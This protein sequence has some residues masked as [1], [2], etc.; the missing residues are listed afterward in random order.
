MS[1]PP[2]ISA[3]YTNSA[4]INSFNDGVVD[5]TTEQDGQGLK[6]IN[7]TTSGYL[8]ISSAGAIVSP[9]GVATY[10]I[11]FKDLSAITTNTTPQELVVV[12]TIAVQDATT[13]PP[14]NI[15]IQAGV[16]G[17]GTNFGIEYSSSTD[18]DF[19]IFCDENN[20][21]GVLYKQQGFGATTTQTKIKQG[22]ITITDTA[23]A[24]V[25]TT[26]TPQNITITNSGLSNTP[27][28]TL[29]SGTGNAII[30]EEMYNQR[31]AQTGE[32]NRMGFYAKNSAGTK[33][34][35]ARFHTNAPTITAGGENGRIDLAV[36]RSGAIT[37][38][39]SL[40]GSANQVNCLRTLDMN[41]NQINNIF[42][43]N[44]TFFSTLAPQKVSYLTANDSTPTSNDPNMRQLYI[45]TGVPPSLQSVGTAPLGS[46]SPISASATYNGNTYVGTTDGQIYYT[47]DP[48]GSWFNLGVLL[49]GQINCFKEFNGDLYF[50]GAFTSDFNTSTTYNNIGR[51]TNTPA[52]V[53]ITWSNIGQTGLNNQ[54]L[55]F[56]T[57]NNYLY[58]GGAFTQDG[59]NI[60]TYNFLAIVDTTNN[61]YNTNNTSTDGFNNYVRTITNDTGS[62]RFIIGGDFSTFTTGGSSFTQNYYTHIDFDS[63]TSYNVFGFFTLNPSL[64]SSVNVSVKDTNTN[65]IIL[66]GSFTSTGYTDYMFEMLWNGS[67]Y[68][69]Q[70]F[71]YTSPSTSPSFLTR[72]L[73]TSYIYWGQSNILYS[74]QG[75]SQTSPVGGSFSTAVYSAWN[76]DN[77]ATNS[78]SQ[79]PVVLY[80]RNTSNSINITLN[81]TLWVQGGASASTAINLANKGNSCE[82]IWNA[83]SA[84]WYLVSNNGATFS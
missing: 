74:S 63:S 12:N 71:S 24:N 35:Y 18:Q 62:N 58:I 31:T 52:I 79:N 70:N 42:N 84:E 60:N 61:I 76:A 50:G 64:S 68:Q 21:G 75:W 77:F 73:G 43:A 29:N 80:F 69:P 13:T 33:T 17:V 83:N 72:S 10:P 54:V 49:N 25:G 9:D 53:P 67:T 3:N 39:L 4:V 32:F 48:N 51:I 28:L 7:N 8:E 36:R 82:L 22:T 19:T 78:S 15:Q 26:L 65:A 66:G 44:T 27:V 2:T 37:D 45:N 46:W 56:E 38:F 47:N 55:C 11:N 34:E 1:L 20:T 81:S 23:N 5:F 6:I 41:S 59:G 16:I 40:N 57:Y 30:Y 14:N